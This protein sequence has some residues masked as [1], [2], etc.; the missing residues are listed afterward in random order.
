MLSFEISVWIAGGD[1]LM[2]T[3]LLGH[4]RDSYFSEGETGIG[5]ISFVRD[6]IV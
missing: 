5:C 2:T 4:P 3:W 1:I 6:N